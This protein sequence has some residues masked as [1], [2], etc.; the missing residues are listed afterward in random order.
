MLVARGS[1]DGKE[2]V[3]FKEI[4]APFSAGR[5]NSG[6]SQ[7]KFKFVETASF[8]VTGIN[9]ARSVTLGLHDGDTLVPAGKVAI[10]QNQ[11]I[12]VIGSVVEVRYLYAYRQSGAI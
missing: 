11:S 2:G 5:P 4:D 10:P 6:G 12:P 7:R 1:I 8:G 3:V 9:Q